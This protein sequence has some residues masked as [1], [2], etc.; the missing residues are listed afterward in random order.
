MLFVVST[1]FCH[2]ALAKENC[3]LRYFFRKGGSHFN[4]QKSL[5]ANGWGMYC[6]FLEKFR[7]LSKIQ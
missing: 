1:F 3:P 5:A 2:K 7:F 6:I 4:H